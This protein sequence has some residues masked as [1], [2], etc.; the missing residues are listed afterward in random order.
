MHRS[1]GLTILR[2]SLAP[3]GAVVKTAGFDETVFEGTEMLVDLTRS[4]GLLVTLYG[5]TPVP[6]FAAPVTTNRYVPTGS[7]SVN[8]QVSFQVW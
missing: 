3:E 7:H 4:N 1:G 5:A 2:G 6:L 8:C